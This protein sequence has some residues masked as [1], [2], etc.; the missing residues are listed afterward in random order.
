MDATDLLPQQLLPRTAP[1]NLRDPRAIIGRHID[2]RL[3]PDNA[4]AD[5]ADALA[6]AAEATHSVP[7]VAVVDAD[8]AS[9]L[10]EADAA[11]A[12]APPSCALPANSGAFEYAH[13]ALD[14]PRRAAARH[15]SAGAP[16]A[17]RVSS[18][19]PVADAA[20]QRFRA[21]ADVEPGAARAS[22]HPATAVVHAEAAQRQSLGLQQGDA[23]VGAPTRGSSDVETAGGSRAPQEVDAQCSIFVR[24]RSGAITNDDATALT[25]ADAATLMSADTAAAADAL[26]LRAESAKASD[27]AHDA[28]IECGSA[29]DTQAG[30]R[31]TS[32][33]HAAA[34]VPLDAALAATNAAAAS[35]V[36][37]S[38]TRP[39]DPAQSDSAQQSYS[40]AGFRTPDSGCSDG[41][42]AA[43][44]ADVS[45]AGKTDEADTPDA[46]VVD[47]AAA[48]AGA[49]V[50]YTVATCAAA[51]AAGAAIAPAS[52]DFL[53]AVVDELDSDVPPVC[54][55]VPQAHAAHV[56]PALA[57]AAAPAAGAAAA[58]V[59][60]PVG[61][62]AAG[63]SA[64][65]RRATGPL[66]ADARVAGAAVEGAPAAE[67]N[68][69]EAGADI[70]LETSDED[71]V[72]TD[73]TV[74]KGRAGWE[75]HF[76]GL[77]VR[78]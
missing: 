47:A 34:Y 1:I 40:F 52:N 20:T 37:A 76:T 6:S 61:N 4:A 48:A 65:N 39:K 73:A 78:C 45:S 14:S 7:S 50:A 31:V 8:V 43:L 58:E 29:A 24:A 27:A 49:A 5:G 26:E 25:A 57:T 42:H 53:S 3:P 30:A 21:A 9:Q 51:P 17:P 36:T 41:A 33:A 60:S 15:A 70:L 56:L 10:A 12:S 69:A 44:A 16:S 23:L 35:G 13:A 28:R 2:P 32:A 54:A 22:A 38:V 59:P 11:M 55:P 77:P 66:V 18:V 74:V 75:V 64:A 71:G 63:A 62:A 19:S 68:A 46:A 72:C 67:T